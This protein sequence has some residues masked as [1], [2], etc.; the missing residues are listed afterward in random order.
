MSSH[1]CHHTQGVRREVGIHAKIL[2]R[3]QNSHAEDDY[4]NNRLTSSSINCK[5]KSPVL[6]ISDKEDAYGSNSD[7]YSFQRPAT[8]STEVKIS[9]VDTK[10]PIHMKQYSHSKLNE[11][12]G[13]TE[14]QVIAGAV[15]GLVVGLATEL[16]L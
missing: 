6:S 4:Q 8:T 16:V 11:S 12:V 10:E 7:S 14:I 2:N 9:K 3:I 13:H 1:F 15:L 5:E